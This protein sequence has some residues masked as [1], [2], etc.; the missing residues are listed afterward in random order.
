MMFY[1]HVKG[2]RGRKE[3]GWD[4]GGVHG[5]PFR[6]CQ[7]VFCDLGD[8]SMAAYLYSG[9]LVGGESVPRGHWVM[10]GT[11]VV[12]TTGGVSGIQ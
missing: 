7:F 11:F 4:E 5:G 9:S 1:H 6:D 3:G 10:V 2:G 8:W 12:V